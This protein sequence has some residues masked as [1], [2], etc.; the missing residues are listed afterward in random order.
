M[1]NAEWSKTREDQFDALENVENLLLLKL[2]ILNN[3]RLELYKN[4]IINEKGIE[5]LKELL[6]VDGAILLDIDSSDDDL[7][8]EFSKGDM[9]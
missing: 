9:M 5:S 7:L 2:G 3:F 1:I 6:K 8:D 4:K